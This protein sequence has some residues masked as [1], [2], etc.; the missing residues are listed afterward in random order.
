[1]KKKVKT[2]PDCGWDGT[3]YA[4]GLEDGG[5]LFEQEICVKCVALIN[6][7]ITKGL[8]QM[9]AAFRAEVKR[10]LASERK[11]RTVK[12]DTRSV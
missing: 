9:S 2:C 7:S 12:T 10:R 1:M 5:L 8:K 11:I 4:I 3:A 6:N